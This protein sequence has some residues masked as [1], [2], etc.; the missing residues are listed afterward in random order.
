MQRY[1]RPRI[2]IAKCDTVQTASVH[3]ARFVLKV[4]DNVIIFD[5]QL[6][7]LHRDIFL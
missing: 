4:E 3:F 2:C 1:V 7:V 5:V 6:T